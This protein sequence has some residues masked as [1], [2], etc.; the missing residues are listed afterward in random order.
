TIIRKTVSRCLSFLKSFRLLGRRP[1]ETLRKHRH[2]CDRAALVAPM[3]PNPAQRGFAGDL[4]LS[5]SLRTQ[6]AKLTR[7]LS[8]SVGIKTLCACF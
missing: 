6:T 4:V 8:Q 3:P 2:L 5:L 7:P 1:P